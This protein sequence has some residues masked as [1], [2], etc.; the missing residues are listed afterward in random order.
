MVNFTFF[1][2]R[3]TESYLILTFVERKWEATKRKANPLSNLQIPRMLQ[4][5]SRRQLL[6]SL[7]YG[8]AIALLVW[9]SPRE[10]GPWDPPP[11]GPFSF[12]VG[13]GDTQRALQYIDRRARFR[14]FGV[15]Y[16]ADC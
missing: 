3:E 4:T 10:K 5:L 8:E 14:G 15:H 16:A 11:S 9:L 1:C 13:R 2:L 7:L 12:V 6:L